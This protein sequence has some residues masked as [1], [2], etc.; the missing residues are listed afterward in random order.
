MAEEKKD[1]AK[2]KDAAAATAKPGAKPGE[3]PAEK[4][5]EKGASNNKKKILILALAAVV[6]LGGAGAAYW[7]LRPAPDAAEGAQAEDAAKDPKAAKGKGEK[8]AEKKAENKKP[9]FVEMEMITVNLKDPDKFLQIKLTLELHNPDAA[10]PIKEMMPILRNAV[11]PVLSS[12]DPT[13][14]ATP[15]GKEKLSTQVAE[16]ANKSLAGAEFADAVEA[17]LITHM[18]IQ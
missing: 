8:A 9:T 5:A 17:A 2:G 13:E 6:L 10:E 12:Q 11:I 18:I 16:A 1:A 3:K 7:F 14:L 15:E 4:P